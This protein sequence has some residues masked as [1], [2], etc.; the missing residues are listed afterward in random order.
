MQDTVLDAL[1]KLQ[2]PARRSLLS[3][4]SW[5]IEAPLARLIA[6]TPP[7]GP[8]RLNLGCGDHRPA[9]WINADFATPRWLLQRRALPDW[10]F[11][12]TRAW[13]CGDDYFEAIHCEHVLEHFPYDVGIRML[14][15]CRRV[16]GPGGL[17]RLSVPDVAR[18]VEAYVQ[19]RGG[20]QP[21]L[22]AAY[23]PGSAA[24][25]RLTQ[26]DGH[27]SVWDAATLIGVLGDL[28]FDDAQER[29]FGDSAMGEVI[30]RSD[31]AWE[32]CYVEARKPGA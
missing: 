21:S 16:L 27:L 23:G 24:I 13:P 2:K 17:L 1:E 19:Q 20:A 32:S 31:R 30:D 8:R 25:S 22:L 12:A 3:A 15:E 26:C 10:S 4:L 28:G 11:D 9:N 6:R 18:Y 7:P 29:G 5:Q 14:R